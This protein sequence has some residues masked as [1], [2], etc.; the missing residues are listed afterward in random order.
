MSG[1]F[2]ISGGVIAML[3]HQKGEEPP[4]VTVLGLCEL[5]ALI[6]EHPHSPKLLIGNHSY[7]R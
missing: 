4:K 2:G 6:R 3:E 5:F 1:W 7:G